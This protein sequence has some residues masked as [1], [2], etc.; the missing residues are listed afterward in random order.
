M[1]IFQQPICGSFLN[2]PHPPERILGL[3]ESGIRSLFHL[4]N[5]R[6]ADLMDN[7]HSEL[8]CKIRDQRWWIE[9]SITICLTHSITIEP[10][11]QPTESVQAPRRIRRSISTPSLYLNEEQRQQAVST[12]LDEMKNLPGMALVGGHDLSNTIPKSEVSSVLEIDKTNIINNSIRP[13]FSSNSS[14]LVMGVSLPLIKSLDLSPVL[15]NRTDEIKQLHDPLHPQDGYLT[16]RTFK[17]DSPLI[18]PLSMT[19][20][21][22]KEFESCDKLFDKIRQSLKDIGAIQEDVYIRSGCENQNGIP[23]PL[24]PI[25]TAVILRVHPPITA[26]IRSSINT[27]MPSYV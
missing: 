20:L 24:I 19:D 18:S 25:H 26:C 23:I 8:S 17:N 5:Q 22:F 6:N 12:M 3:L 27:K 4:V 15:Q 1:Q 9:A 7:Q 21:P 13:S 10:S 14:P 16:N 11:S 2:P